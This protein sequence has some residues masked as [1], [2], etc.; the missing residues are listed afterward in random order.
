MTEPFSKKREKIYNYLD[1]K[2]DTE[3]IKPYELTI[4]FI[5]NAINLTPQ[6]I[7]EILQKQIFE[8]DI[9]PIN[10][11]YTF[12]TPSNKAKKISKKYK[13]DYS[14]TDF[15]SLII[16]FAIMALIIIFVPIFYEMITFLSTNE[17][18][19]IIASLLI[20]VISYVLGYLLYKCIDFI[21]MK[22]ESIKFYFDIFIPVISL[23]IVSSFICYIYVIISNKEF[24]NTLLA[25]ILLVSIPGGLAL[26]DV[27][28]R[29]KSGLGLMKHQNI[30]KN[31]NNKN[32][33]KEKATEISHPVNKGDNKW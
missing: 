5:S 31:P 17:V 28:E 16:G 1:E 10:L 29:K 3:D 9:S 33:S 19:F 20:L 14:V 24:D 12:F 11:N 4:E 21:S 15:F 18:G 25:A 32:K 23:L 22:Y 13:R 2:T 30:T 6:E 27:I 7:S 26:S 8:G